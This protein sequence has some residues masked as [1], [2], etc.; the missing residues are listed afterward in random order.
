MEKIDSFEGKHRFLSN[1]YNLSP[2][3]I[4]YDDILWASVEAAYQAMK[5]MDR[6]H[7]I[8]ISW[9][10]ASQA[11]KAGRS[12]KLRGDWDQVKLTIME[13]LL[14]LKFS[15]PHLQELLTGTGDAE[16]IEGNWWGDQFWGICRGI[17][18]NHLGK[19]L[20]KIRA[21]NRNVTHSVH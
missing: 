19:L 2:D 9:M 15:Q 13:E 21:E 18:Q 11:K 14:R 16:L 10:S 5:T 7:R 12:L 3:S 17:G 1:F 4:R 6:E 8:E 20:M